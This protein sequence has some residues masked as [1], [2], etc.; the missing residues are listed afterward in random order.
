MN[1]EQL[2][3]RQEIAGRMEAVMYIVA[4]VSVVAGVFA[5]LYYGLL[6]SLAFLILGALAYGLARVFE[7]LAEV[8]TSRAPADKPVTATVPEGSK[9]NA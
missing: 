5:F 6:P 7:L 2:Y 1:R 9:S 3:E 4:G 8:F